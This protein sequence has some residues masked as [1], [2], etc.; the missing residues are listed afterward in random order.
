MT[1]AL[2]ET[3]G[4][5]RRFGGLSA[6][7]D[8]SIAVE[9]GEI[10]A[11]IG[12]NGAGKTTL[13][14]MI[15]G[16]LR[17]SAGT[18]RF[19]G[20]DITAMPSW[21]RVAAGIVYTFQ[22]TSI[23]GSLQVRENVAL[24]AQRRL[25]V[26]PGAWLHLDEPALAARVEDSLRTLGLDESAGRRAG[27][28]P[29]GHQRLLEVAMG[30]ALEPRLLILDEPTQGLAEH[31][32][33]TFCERV[34]DIASRATVMLIEHNMRV[35]LRLASRITVMDQGR[36]IAD[37]DPAERRV[38]PGSP[39]RLPGP[40]V[41]RNRAPNSGAP[42]RSS[43]VAGFP[44]GPAGRE[45]VPR[46]PPN[47]GR[48]GIVLHLENVRAGYGRVEVLR[49]VDL[50]L[51]PGRILGLL[52]RNGAGKT[53]TIRAIMGLVD[54][55]R[56]SIRIEGTELVGLPPHR[57]PGHGLA[58]VPQGRR[59]F[60]E[61][62][63]EENLRLG[64]LAGRGESAERLDFLFDLFPV[65]KERMQTSARRLSGGQQQM[66]AMARALASGPRVLLLDEPTEGLQPSLVDRILEAVREL[67]AAGTTL[68]LV[69]QKVE[70]ALAVADRIAFI[71]NGRI[72]EHATPES[73]ARDP[74]PLIRYV[75]V[76]RGE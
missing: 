16:R 67:R 36:V 50:V 49:G 37:G 29:Y 34:R 6:V 69:E 20:R 73:L 51:E 31:E 45:R 11:V 72:L 62:T 30:L 43:M 55:L 1:T 47:R 21:R 2:L 74:E 9:P 8:V 10:R 4:L 32:I 35:V 44:D 63:V 18:V 12:P 17:P 3:E 23:Y 59:L 60:P 7:E 75:G 54:G 52:G 14:G 68:L 38:G 58:W 42:Y 48:S 70:A 57:V 71:E 19:E 28:L 22:V 13:V 15:C 76:R 25:M 33:D 27:E 26:S 64:A 53:T 41:M 46:V 24:A 5:G 40:A 66:V 61:M 56:G 65:L 39:A